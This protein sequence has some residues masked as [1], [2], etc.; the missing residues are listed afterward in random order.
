VSAARRETLPYPPIAI[1]CS[2]LL[3]LPR[4]LSHIFFSISSEQVTAG[5]S[6]NGNE[7]KEA[8]GRLADEQRGALAD[9]QHPDTVSTNEMA[10]ALARVEVNQ[11]RGQA[12]QHSMAE[13]HNS[14][15]AEVIDGQ[16]KIQHSVPKK[17]VPSRQEARATAA[18]AQG[19]NLDFA[20]IDSPAR[21]SSSDSSIY[22]SPTASP[23]SSPAKLTGVFDKA[24]AA[25][26]ER[27][28][29]IATGDGTEAGASA[30]WPHFG[31]T[32]PSPSFKSFTPAAAVPSFK[33]EATP[34]IKGFAE[35]D[36]AQ[37][38]R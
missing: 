22:Y 12:N 27:I 5:V 24:A 17:Q 35:A 10:E 33:A 30:T 37:G 1:A 29:A 18:A 3:F 36:P 9:K 34:P 19:Q 15:R 14:F 6:S 13:A 38:Y 32:G 11:A 31:Q 21:S 2:S 16:R 7:E 20:S 28:G 8:N 26:Q 4:N 23:R 25:M